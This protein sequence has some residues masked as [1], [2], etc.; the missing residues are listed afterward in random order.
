MSSGERELV[1]VPNK[2]LNI[3]YKLKRIDF[4]KRSRQFAI[5][6]LD[7]SISELSLLLGRDQAGTA[8]RALPRVPD[9]APPSL[10]LESLQ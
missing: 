7:R 9:A 10:R 3:A 2:K 6:M 8:Y 5:N 1:F 4:R